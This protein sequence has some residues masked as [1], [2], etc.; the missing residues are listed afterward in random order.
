MK[1]V[2]IDHRICKIEIP[3]Q[4]TIIFNKSRLCHRIE[5]WTKIRIPQFFCH[6]IMS[7]NIFH[8]L[9]QQ[10][11]CHRYPWEEYQTKV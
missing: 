8:S 7:P 1:G 9:Q 3:A 4:L 2:W 11:P 5:E 6:Q 10:E